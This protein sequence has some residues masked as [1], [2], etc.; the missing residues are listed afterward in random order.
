VS[1]RIHEP[2]R[3]AL[4]TGGAAPAAFT[5]NGRRYLVLRV[6]AVWKEV[7]P[8]WDGDGERTFFRVTAQEPDPRSASPAFGRSWS[9][10]N[11]TPRGGVFELSLDRASGSWALVRLM[12]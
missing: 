3:V 7:G 12:D 8:W 11:P 4:Q 1:K 10:P 2:V 5:W 6:E 9:S